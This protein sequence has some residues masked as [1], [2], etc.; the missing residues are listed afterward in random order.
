[1]QADQ[2]VATYVNGALKV[3]NVSSKAMGGGL[4]TCKRSIPFGIG[5]QL[6]YFGLDLQVLVTQ[7]DMPL[8]GRLEIDVKRVDTAASGTPIPN[9]ANGS[10]QLNFSTGDW[11]ID[12]SPPGWLATG[13]KPAL[14]HDTW[15]PVRIRYLVQDGKFSVLSTAWG[16]QAFNVPPS[17]QGLP[18]QQSNWAQVAAVQLQTEIL[19]RGALTVLYKGIQ[20]SYSDKPY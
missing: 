2:F 13:F 3:T 5:A 10:T 8:L 18:L 7:W 6:P 11:Q 15:T 4:V 19:A 14:A 9:V 20:L 1:V 12:G 17:M 16:T